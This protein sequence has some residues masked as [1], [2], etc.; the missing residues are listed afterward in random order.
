MMAD[1]EHLSAEQREFIESMGVF[2][3]YFGLPRIIGRLM[4][5]LMLADH[6]LTLD[7]MAR[8]LLVSRASV[9][10]NIRIALHHGY[11][12]RV[13]IP[14]DRRDY[15]RFSD[16]V[17]EKRS[18]VTLE[19]S[20]VSRAMAER[21]LASLGPDDV[22]ARAHLEEMRDYCEF[23]IEEANTMLARWRERKRAARVARATRATQR[24]AHADE[25]VPDAGAGDE[26]VAIERDS[27]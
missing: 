7:D 14:G 2:F 1:S 11:A 22:S 24:P 20:N 23:S 10:T 8:A 16:D 17:W 3:E 13:G 18:Q 27:D 9:S 21:G 26:S 5:L 12:V 6:P 15:Y 4:G 25:T 19:A